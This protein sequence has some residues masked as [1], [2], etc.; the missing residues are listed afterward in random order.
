M[1]QKQQPKVIKVE[2]D[3]IIQDVNFVTFRKNTDQEGIGRTS[4]EVAIISVP[5]IVSI[6]LVK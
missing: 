1:K 2:C 6:R 5:D 4:V 3:T